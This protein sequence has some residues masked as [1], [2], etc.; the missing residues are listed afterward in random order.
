MITFRLPIR[1]VNG[2]NSREHWAKRAARA[3]AQRTAAKLATLSAASREVA[4]ALIFAVTG[5]RATAARVV[6]DLP[7]TITITRIGPSS[8]DSDGLAI[9]AKH[10]RDGIADAL[11][12]DDGD[13][14][15]TWL[16]DQRKG[17]AATRS[18]KR[19]AEYAVEV[20]I[21]TSDAATAPP[22]ADRVPGRVDGPPA[23]ESASGGQPGG[24]KRASERN[25]RRTG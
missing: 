22:T 8:L 7:L 20:S 10:I 1:L 9:S 11:G 14:R 2:A 18:P 12:I 3:K 25:R 13:P 4:P 24:K 17:R 21:A 15:L 16:Y 23:G 5:Q 6:V 19:P